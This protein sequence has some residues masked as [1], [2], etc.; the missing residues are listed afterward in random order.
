MGGQSIVGPLLRDY[1]SQHDTDASTLDS[2]RGKLLSGPSRHMI[3]LGVQLL[4]G[5]KCLAITNW[6]D[7]GQACWSYRSFYFAWCQQ[8]LFLLSG[9]SKSQRVCKLHMSSYGSHGGVSVAECGVEWY[10]NRKFAKQ[11][12]SIVPSDFHCFL[13]HA[14]KSLSFSIGCCWMI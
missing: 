4:P 7:F 11:C 9:F 1:G 5:P 6:K 10:V 13:E 12:E 14:N 2:R 8:T 3:T